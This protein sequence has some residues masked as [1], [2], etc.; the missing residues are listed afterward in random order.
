MRRNG[1]TL[2]ELLV[3]IAIIAILAAI[4]FPVFAQAREKARQTSCVSNEKQLALAMLAYSQDYDETFPIGME[5]DGDWGPINRY[6]PGLV[7]PYVK[8]F[9][10]FGCPSDPDGGRMYRGGSHYPSWL[11]GTWVGYGLTYAVNGL[12]GTAWMPG[13][14]L[15]GAS[16]AGGQTGWL[17]DAGNKQAAIQRVADTIM[18]SEL[19]N[20]DYDINYNLGSISSNCCAWGKWTGMGGPELL[21]SPS[22]ELPDG[23]NWGS[24]RIPNGT[25]NPNAPYPD[26]PNG[27]VSAHHSEKANFAFIDGHVKAMTPSATNPNPNN[28]PAAN[29]WDGGRM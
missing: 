14:P 12:Y 28:N 1:F 3:V 29:M 21:F 5:S 17:R 19:Y 8:N 10:I 18:M 7:Q 16:G 24:G 4:L 2:I 26:G 23:A 13:F 22:L 9:A 6:W 25:R 20:S 27:S 11:T 15:A